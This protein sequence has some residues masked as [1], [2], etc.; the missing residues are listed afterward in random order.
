[1]TR[2]KSSAIQLEERMI[3]TKEDFYLGRKITHL[4]LKKG[5]KA[6]DYVLVVWLYHGNDIIDAVVT[7]E[8]KIISHQQRLPKSVR[9]ERKDEDRTTK[10]YIKEKEGKKKKL[11]N[12]C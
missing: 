8:F 11:C 4:K 3:I 7:N 1:M 6:G 12:F 10:T 2:P 9:E 5:I